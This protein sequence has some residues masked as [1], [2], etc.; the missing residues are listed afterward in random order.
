MKHSKIVLDNNWKGGERFLNMKKSNI[1]TINDGILTMI[2]DNKS[3]PLNEIKKIELKTDIVRKNSGSEILNSL[4]NALSG[5]IAN[6]DELVNI[7]LV[8]TYGDQPEKY[9]LTLQKEPVIKNNL[10]YH[11]LNQRMKKLKEILIADIK[12]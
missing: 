6:G 4:A 11:Q 9:L 3:I 1:Y 5:S 8:I 10:E 12:K 7:N 2:E